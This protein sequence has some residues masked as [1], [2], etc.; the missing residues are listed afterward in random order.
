MTTQLLFYANAIPVSSERHRDLSIKAGRDYSFAAKTNSVPL[1]AVEF[2]R[3]AA[4]YAIVF[5]GAGDS[6]MP[7]AVLGSAA[8]QNLFVKDDGTWDGKYVPAFVRRYPFVFSSTDQGKTFTLCVDEVFNGCNRDGR[9]ERLFDA[10]GER[11]QYLQTVLSFLQDYQAHFQRTKAFCARLNELGL[12]EPMQAQFTLPDGERKNLT[13]FM[14][15]SRAKLKA[16]DD[17]VLAGM[18]RSDEME[19]IF[20]HL[21]SMQNFGNMLQRIGA[22]PATTGAEAASEASELT[23][24]EDAAPPV[25]H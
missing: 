20:L 11:T 15:V 25:A 21:Q 6:I 4:E 19:M 24:D 14:V 22:K 12:F 5:A 8:D 17:A 16:L 1:T 3:A 13:G 9:G 2:Q 10:S 23:A 7:V 18:V